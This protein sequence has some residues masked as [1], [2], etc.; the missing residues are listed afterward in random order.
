M[1]TIV[2]PKIHSYLDWQL[3]SIDAWGWLDV[4]RATD[5]ESFFSLLCII[6]NV[7]FFPFTWEMILQVK[8]VNRFERYWGRIYELTNEYKVA[9]CLQIKYHN[10]SFAMCTNMIQCH[11]SFHIWH[12]IIQL[13]Q[14]IYTSKQFSLQNLPWAKF[15][16]SSDVKHFADIVA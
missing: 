10:L 5:S 9:S 4:N 13:K 15:Y 12:P 2:W 16:L 1:T 8:Y 14:C 6:C 11:L 7:S 3:W